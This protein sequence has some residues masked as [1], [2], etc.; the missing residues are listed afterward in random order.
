LVETS[1]SCNINQLLSV[2]A[3]RPSAD[4]LQNIEKTVEMV[5]R[6]SVK[7]LFLTLTEPSSLGKR[8]QNL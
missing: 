2:L 7:S 4:T 6:R 3:E 1:K 8:D 5:A